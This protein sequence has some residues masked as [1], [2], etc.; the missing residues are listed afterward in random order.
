[1]LSLDTERTLAA[2]LFQIA[3]IEAEVEASRQELCKN[4]NFDVYS[5]FRLID[6]Q[7]NG[8]INIID[9]KNFLSKRN[10][11]ITRLH[12]ELLI[13]QYDSN[14]DQMLSLEE[15]QPLVLPSENIEL[16]EET[17]K[18]NVFPPSLYV[19][20]T[21]A[22]HIELEANIQGQLQTLKR[23]LFTKHDFSA[24]EA[25][26]IIDKDRA[27]FINI[28]R[29]R[30]FLIKNGFSVSFRDIDNIIRRV[31]ID[32]DSKLSY[33]EFTVGILPINR[34]PITSPG[35]RRNYSPKRTQTRLS[36]RNTI[37]SDK[38]DPPRSS[39]TGKLSRSVRTKLFPTV[40]EPD[41]SEILSIFIEQISM[42]KTI[43]NC[44]IRLSKH[45][46]FNLANLIRIFDF[47][48]KGFIECTDI[49]NVLRELQ[50][51]YHVDEVYLLIRHYCTSHELKLSYF[52]LEKI[53]LSNNQFYYNLVKA[54]KPKICQDRFRAF[55]ADTLDGIVSLLKTSLRN[56]NNS[57]TLRKKLSEK[58]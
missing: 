8:K 35:K 9:L 52:D 45:F 25:F 30:D 34:K 48:A 37:K 55:S 4:P 38:K 15:F 47:R 50:I 54:N 33:E 22:R 20:S 23:N 41:I 18:R 16:R 57:E 10:I 3:Q 29:I 19:E 2:L 7:T 24:I 36:S 5:T 40:S 39:T 6:T 43:E 12:L 26:R 1:M 58:P 51:P 42:H 46:D 11:S 53:F 31:D 27:N 56:E 32:N 28:Y 21:L 49:E 17:L 14:M 13:N 44:K